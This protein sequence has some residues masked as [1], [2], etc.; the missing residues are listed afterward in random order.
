MTDGAFQGRSFGFVDDLLSTIR[1]HRDI[2]TFLVLKLQ[3][4]SYADKQAIAFALGISHFHSL[5]LSLV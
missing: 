2:I 1:P 4:L 5:P 3:T